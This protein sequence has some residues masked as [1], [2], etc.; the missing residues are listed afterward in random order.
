M[1]IKRAF[2]GSQTMY[3]QTTIEN[4]AQSDGGADGAGMCDGR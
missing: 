4:G 3:K 2:A 1:S